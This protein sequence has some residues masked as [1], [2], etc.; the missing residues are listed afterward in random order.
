[1]VVDIK[2]SP[3]SDSSTISGDRNKCY[4]KVSKKRVNGFISGRLA[5][6]KN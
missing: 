1:M 6:G 3:S 5:G 4:C 2:T